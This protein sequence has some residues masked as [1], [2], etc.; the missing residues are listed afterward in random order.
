MGCLT[1]QYQVLCLLSFLFLHAPSSFS[2]SLSS[3]SQCSALL[4][5]NNSFSIDSSLFPPPN[6]IYPHLPLCYTSYPKTASWKEDK[7]C[8]SWD[9]VD[10]DKNTGHVIGLDLSCSWLSGTIHSN[11]TL[12]LL[13]HLRT[14]SLAGNNF[15]PSLISSEFGQFKSLTHLNLSYSYF[16]GQIPSEISQLSSLVSLDL[17]ST[18]NML[19]ETPIW[20]N[21]TLLRELHLDYT[22][23]SSIRPKSLMN[24]SSSLTTLS[25]HGCNL[26]GKL[27][28]SILLLPSLQ[29]LDLGSN[30]NLNVSLPKSNWSSS[31]LK[32][33]DLSMI[34][35][36][37]EIP[38]FIGNLKSLKYLDLSYCNFSGPIPTLLG[39][40]TQITDLILSWNRF[41]GS[42]PTSLGNLTQLTLLDLSANKFSGMIP[43]CL[44]NLTKLT[45]LFLSSNSF[46]GL[47]PSSLLNLPNLSTLYLD[48]NQLVGPLPN[49]VS[50][51]NLTHLSLSSNFLNGTLPSWLFNLP[52]LVH[53]H[54]SSNQ[55]IGEIG[56]FK[57]NSLEE[58]G[59]GHNKLQG[60]LPR[61]IS[62]LVNLTLLSLPSNNLSIMLD[63]EIFSELKNLQYLDFSNNLVSINNNVAYTLPNLKQINLSSSNISEF[64]IFLR[65]ATNLQNLDLSNNSIYGQ[66]PRWLGDMGRDSLY[67]LDLSY[68]LLQGPFLNLKFLGLLYIFI[69]N[70]KLSGEIPCLICKISLEVLDLSHNDLSGTVPK[71]LV[72]SNV[73]KVLDLRMNSL[74]GTIPTTFYKRNDFR[75]INLNGNQLEG[76]LPRSLAYCT[77]LEVL[78]LGN[79]KINGVFPYWLGSLQNLRVLVIRSNR[80]QGH[81]GN[82]KT[83]FPFP[84][85]RIIDI[86][87]NQFN[88]PLPSKYFKHL[89]AMMSVHK[90]DV[91]LDYMGEMYYSDSVN[92]M[93]KGHDTKLVRILTVFTSI[94][95]SNN[96]FTGEMPKIIGRLTSLKGLNFS[97]N[98]LTGYIPSSFGNL[99]NLE[100]LDLSF[101][102]LSGEIPN[103]THTFRKAV[104]YI[105]Q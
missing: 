1:W 45:S 42:I 103:Q 17:S 49:H 85:L 35:F 4:Q 105:Q 50:G 39:N 91:A 26:Q 24:L 28:N 74:H 73:L 97:H 14:L 46:N 60:S 30:P 66:A 96:R 37:G 79:N 9:G 104:L 71:C 84:N 12:F 83:K 7:H 53:L 2:S 8:C 27:K 31:S 38:D 47:V 21:L 101:N 82:P 87:N 5:F 80:F 43:A 88:G 40:L 56:E 90:S 23:M 20:N 100:S 61:S 65:T 59:L 68:N 6:N 77:N 52:S 69:S 93:L 58:L 64:P 13:R 41:I 34:R 15:Y 95:F 99:T 67:F 18:N 89:N 76:P 72:H 25:L 63:F 78:D 3:N 44:G 10:C 48:Y 75:T 54:I 57:S 11:S 22:D 16:S 19:I 92:V 81:I 86:S 51:L 29:T 33:L 62:R 36:S 102:K 98:N 70:N 55:F 32:F 94:D